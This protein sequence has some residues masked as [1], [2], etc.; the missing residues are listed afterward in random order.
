MEKSSLVLTEK[1][2][3]ETRGETRTSND[4][5]SIEGSPSGKPSLSAGQELE[6]VCGAAITLK[7]TG[8]VEIAGTMHV[9]LSVGAAS[10]RLCRLG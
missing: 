3:L 5:I 10:T 1:D 6:F 8:E 2:H 7:P 9:K 4:P